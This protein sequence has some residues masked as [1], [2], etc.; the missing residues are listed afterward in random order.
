M[1]VFYTDAVK[2]PIAGRGSGFNELGLQTLAA[3]MQA[4]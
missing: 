1:F 4:W 2:L 3:G